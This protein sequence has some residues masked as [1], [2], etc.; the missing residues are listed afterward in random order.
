MRSEEISRAVGTDVREEDGIVLVDVLGT[1]WQGQPGRARPPPLGRQ[2]ARGGPRCRGNGRSSGPTG[3]DPS[4]NLILGLHPAL[5][6]RRATRS[7]RS[8]GSGSPGS[9]V[10]CRPAPTWSPWSRP[11][12]WR[13][14]QLVQYLEFATPP[15]DER[16]DGCWQ[17]G[18]TWPPFRSRLPLGRDVCVPIPVQVP[19]R[20]AGCETTLSGRRSRSSIG[21]RSVAIEAWNKRTG[22]ARADGP[23]P[24]RSE[25]SWWPWWS[26]PSPR[27]PCWLP[28]FTDV[29]FRRI[30][31]AC[32]TPSGSKRCP[33]SE[34]SSCWESCYRN[35]RT[36]FHGLDQLMDPVAVPRR[37]AASDPVTFERCSSPDAPAHRGGVGRAQ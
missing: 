23:R 33:A 22:P 20:R 21:S 12:V 15:A 13:S 3:P 1:G 24:F 17:G 4:R 30:S 34:R 5:R 31:P 27:A 8:S 16:P 11:P 2:V 6:R 19:V 26:V 18:L 36:R 25:R 14:S 29:L 35:V 9:W 37:T 28:D 32:A 10:T 7:S